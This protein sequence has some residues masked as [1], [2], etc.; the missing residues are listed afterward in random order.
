MILRKQRKNKY[1]LTSIHLLL[2][3]GET[4][5]I[6]WRT[7]SL[8]PMLTCTYRGI[9]YQVAARQSKIQ[10][11]G[12]DRNHYIERINEAQKRM[13]YRGIRHSLIAK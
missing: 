9:S 4:Q 12:Y 6:L 11:L 1:L 10:E 13:T 3:H 7:Q 2:R 8:F 5:A